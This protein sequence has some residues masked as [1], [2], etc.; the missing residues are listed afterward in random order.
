MSPE[1]QQ[2]VESLHA[3][4]E[5]L[6]VSLPYEKG[7]I[8]P[9]KGVCLFSE[10]GDPFYVGRSNNIAQRRRQHTRR[11]SQSNQAA[12]AAL[13]ARD[14]TG[15]EVDFR[16]G[17]RERLLQDQE[18]MDAFRRAKERVRAMEFR[19]VAEPDQTRQALL[20]IYCAITLKTPHNDFGTH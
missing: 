3:K 1:F 16:K 20:E 2:A 11:C 6:I 8:L 12:L 15:R 19:A 17:A 5:H 10:N 7:A 18:F 13:M 4:F 14:E 9:I